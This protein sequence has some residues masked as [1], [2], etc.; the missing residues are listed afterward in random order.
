M[1]ITI[2]DILWVSQDLQRQSASQEQ[3]V[4]IWSFRLL[5]DSDI[6]K[7]WLSILKVIDS[8]KD[9]WGFEEWVKLSQSKVTLYVIQPSASYAFKSLNDNFIS[10]I[11][12]YRLY[13]DS[14]AEERFI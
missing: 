2:A 7:I 12:A 6:W 8:V 11:T 14:K 5:E 3:A 10:G 9:A 1:S 13:R 4:P